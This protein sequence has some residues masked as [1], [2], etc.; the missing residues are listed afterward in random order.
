MLGTERAKAMTG[1][2]RGNM[3]VNMFVKGRST[4]SFPRFFPGFSSHSTPN[5]GGHD[6]ASSSVRAAESCKRDSSTRDDEVP[7]TK[8]ASFQNSTTATKR[9]SPSGNSRT[10]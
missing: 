6:S 7:P 5:R 1:A 10:A 2:T 8:S 3:F 9:R 4:F